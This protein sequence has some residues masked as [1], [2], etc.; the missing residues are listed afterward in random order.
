MLQIF[1]PSFSSM[2]LSDKAS[3]SCVHVSVMAENNDEMV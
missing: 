2:T 3:P 1:I